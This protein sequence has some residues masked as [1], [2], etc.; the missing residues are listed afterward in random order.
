MTKRK[1]WYA[2]FVNSGDRHGYVI[3]GTTVEPTEETFGQVF[4]FVTGPYRTRKD[5]YLNTSVAG[6]LV[7]NWAR[8]WCK[9]HNVPADVSV[10]H[11]YPTYPVY[12]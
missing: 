7:R 6:L 10:F 4:K 12:I 5:A 9:L 1:K 8:E 11:D 2:G 3:F